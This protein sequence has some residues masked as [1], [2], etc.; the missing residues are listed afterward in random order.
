MPSL[1]LTP[2]LLGG[3]AEVRPRPETVRSRDFTLCCPWVS[4]G[5]SGGQ[6]KPCVGCSDLAVKGLVVS[7][8]HF[9]HGEGRRGTHTGRQAG[10]PGLVA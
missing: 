3:L 8:L 6:C 10:P 1:A 2:G 7:S 4:F 5:G 9:G